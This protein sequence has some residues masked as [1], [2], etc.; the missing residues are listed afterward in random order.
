M[1]VP[2]LAR[3][4]RRALR[5]GVGG[6]LWTAATLATA[7]G[8]TPQMSPTVTFDPYGARDRPP[9]ARALSAA[10]LR[11]ARERAGSF[12]ETLKAVPSFSQPRDRVTLATSW[13]TVS[14][15]GA[16]EQE[17]TVYWSAPFDVRRRADGALSPVLGGAH[18]LLYFTTN[19]TAASQ[20]LEDR[21]TRGN[22]SRS[23]ADDGL[24]HDAFAMPR[25]LGELGG[26]TVYADMIVFT[27]D[28]RSALEPA[29]VGPLLQA[30]AQRLRKTVADQEAGFANSLRELEASMTPQA[31]AARRAKREE[32]WKTETRDPAA[33]AQRLDAAHR[34]D[35]SDYARQKERMTAP[36]TRD[37]KSVWW[38]PR[39]A[40]DSVQARLAALDATARRSAACARVDSSFAAGYDVRYELAAAAPADCVPMVQVRPDLIDP[41]RPTSEVQLLTVWSRESLCGLPLASGQPGQRGLC[42]NAVPLLRDIDWAALRRNLGW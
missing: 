20:Q 18:R 28:G 39:L 9:T 7:Q 34:T 37:P 42:E 33:L 41:K 32:R 13:A 30:Q 4:W 8:L 11:L 5:F 36:A 40:L 6:V 22:F 17:F 14:P 21:A 38:G 35:E 25:V 1:T 27:R 3:P 24:A 19:R 10:E 15:Q 31:I 26:G 29:P 2:G 16:V 12:Y 23:A